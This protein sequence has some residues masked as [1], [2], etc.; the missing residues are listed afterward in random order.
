M[1]DYIKEQKIR[2]AKML[3]DG[4]QSYDKYHDILDIINTFGVEK[5]QFYREFE[6]LVL[7]YFLTI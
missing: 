1:N 4:I 5:D 3:E 6:K 2:L 7:R